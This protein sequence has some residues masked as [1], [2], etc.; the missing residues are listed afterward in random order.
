M[1]ILTTFWQRGHVHNRFLGWRCWRDNRLAFENIHVKICRS[2]RYPK[3]CRRCVSDRVVAA[4]V[5]QWKPIK[6]SLEVEE[7]GRMVVW[8]TTFKFPGCHGVL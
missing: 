3:R 2:V 1:F 6:A 4:V 7:G 5:S 8:S